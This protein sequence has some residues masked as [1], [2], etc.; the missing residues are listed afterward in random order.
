MKSAIIGLGVIGKVH[1]KVLCTQGREISAICDI[2]LSEAEGVKSSY[3]LACEVFADWIEMLDTAKPDVVHICT[4]HYLH[5]EMVIEALRRNV[6]VLC[7][8][9]L[10]IKYEDIDRI[11]EAERES[12]AQLGVCHQNRYLEVNSF[13]KEYLA[14]KEIAGA[15]GSVAWSRGD[16]YYNSAEWRGTQELE[17][18][19]VLINQA[20]HTLDL[21][22]WLCGEPEEVVAGK[23]NLTLRSVIEVEDSITARFYGNVP[24]SF[25]ATNAAPFN[26]AVQINI[27]LSSGEKLIV[28]PDML[29]VNGEVTL[30]RGQTKILGKACYGNGHEALIDDFYTCIESGKPFSING[31]EGAKVIKLIL[32]AYASDGQ[33]IKI[34]K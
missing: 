8:K 12:S 13:V 2:N 34:K 24:F 29:L 7:E 33:R 1:A 11:L 30:R 3:G 20:L 23:D 22:Q 10:C 28:L 19:G 31:A 17:G 6:N 15:H 9:P 21:V 5:A 26:N 16:D 32:A 25:F 27:R 14:D 4:P 18:G